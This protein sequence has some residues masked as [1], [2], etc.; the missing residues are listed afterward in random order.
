MA[1]RGQIHAQRCCPST[2]PLPEYGPLSRLKFCEVLSVVLST[3][4]VSTRS[5]TP[6]TRL[7]SLSHPSFIL[8]TMIS[9]ENAYSFHW[10]ATAGPADFRNLRIFEEPAGSQPG[11][12]MEIYRVR[13]LACHSTLFVDDPQPLVIL[14]TVS[15][16]GQPLSKCH[17]FIPQTGRHESAFWKF[18]HH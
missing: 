8:S 18:R 7:F 10:A 11:C 4:R 13:T 9:V 5:P 14:A 17:H 1:F 2:H 6:P 16:S 15:S 12:G 3:T